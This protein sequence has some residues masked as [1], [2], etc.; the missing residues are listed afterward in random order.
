MSMTAKKKFICKKY[1]LQALLFLT[2][3]H[4][5]L[6]HAKMKVMLDAQ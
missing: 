2:V 3:Q 6:I 5:S 4:Q 1:S